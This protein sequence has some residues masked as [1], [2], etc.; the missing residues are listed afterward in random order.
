MDSEELKNIDKTV[1]PIHFAVHEFVDAIA[2]EYIVYPVERIKEKTAREAIQ[3]FRNACA[4]AL[5]AVE[6]WKDK[7][8]ASLLKKAIIVVKEEN[9][10]DIMLYEKTLAK[11]YERKKQYEKCSALTRNL[12]SPRAKSRDKVWDEEAVATYPEMNCMI[13][14]FILFGLLLVAW[15]LSYFRVGDAEDIRGRYVFRRNG[16]STDNH[17]DVLGFCQIPMIIKNVVSVEDFDKGEL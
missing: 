7:E 3:V 4:D 5:E 16:P 13:L 8:R 1:E 17:C 2:E 15:M 6:N 12:L 14:C 9:E 11:F 10:S